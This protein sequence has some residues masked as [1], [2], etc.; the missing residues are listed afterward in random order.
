[1]AFWSGQTLARKLPDMIADF[2]PARIDC[3]AYTLAM[4]SQYYVTP[5]KVDFDSRSAVVRELKDKEHFR[6]PSGQ[7]A[8]LLT[9]EV[10][11]LPAN[12]LA[13]ISMK[14]KYKWRGLVNVSGFHVDPGFEGRL[15][16]AVYNAGPSDIQ[17]QRGDPIFLIWFCD[18]DSESEDKYRKTY[19]DAKRP[20]ESIPSDFA[21]AVA[22]HIYSPIT[23]IEDT[24]QNKALLDQ[25]N[26]LGRTFAAIVI[27]ILIGAAT[28]TYK[29]FDSHETR[30]GRIEDRLM[31]SN[32]RISD[33]TPRSE[34]VPPAKDANTSPSGT[35]REKPSTK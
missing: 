8:F 24:R 23:L 34:P 32:S 35:K 22:G 1:M 10:V 9:K 29:Q 30:L 15:I 31:S 11:R 21:S 13:F 14:S 26:W 3:A 19:N 33:P 5:G 4:G 17:I 28:F 16:F 25:I 6:I 27:S 12:V 7:F 20:Q 18:L 2:D